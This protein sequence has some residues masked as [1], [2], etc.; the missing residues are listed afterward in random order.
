[1]PESVGRFRIDE[2]LGRGGMGE[3]Y[4]AFDP[5]L[6]RIVALK[7]VRPDAN[8]PDYLERLYREAQACARLQHPHIV[9]V[10]EAGEIDGLVFIVMEYLQGTSLSDAIRGGTLRFDEKVRALMQVLE[11]LQ[12]AHAQGVIHRDIKPSNVLRLPDGSVKLVDFGLARMSKVETMTASGMVVGTLHYASPEQFR[13]DTLDGRAD[14][15]SAGAL[16]YEMF[17][18]RL[19]FAG[20][21]SSISSLIMSVMSD[22]PPPMNTPHSRML[23]ELEKI[24]SKAMAKQASDRYQTADEMREALA[25]FMSS[26]REALATLEN[27]PETLVGDATANAPTVISMGSGT[28]VNEPRRIGLAWWVAAAVAAALGVAVLAPWSGDAT[29]N[30]PAEAVAQQAAALPDPPPAGPT[31]SAPA[32]NEAP[33]AGTAAPDAAAKISAAPRDAAPP[34]LAAAPAVERTAKELFAA[35]G[36]SAGTGLRYR[37]IQQT[38][39]GEQ[40]VEWS[41]AF[42]SG[43]KVRFAFESNVDG[44]LYVV[45]QGSS[46]QWSVLFPNP[47]INGGRNSIRRGEQYHVPSDDWFEFDNN[48]GVEQIFVFLSRDPM[49]QL[50]GFDRPVTRPE[51]VRASVVEELQHSIRPRD[52]VLARDR[53]AS[54]G[55]KVSQ[56]TYV[57]NRSEVGKAVAA[58][59]TLS[60]GQ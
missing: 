51:S 60:H 29:S 9:T 49:A 22:A 39:A 1:M 46:G 3:V 40:D 13:G 42:H 14:I 17:T 27:A 43:D 10:F 47:A 31:T 53:T 4:K 20:K 35:P 25:R 26:S 54:T 11:A 57:V 21:D 19:P 8:Q 36:A 15:Y 5:T 50:P 24:V 52:L 2:L 30:A 28:V 41:T 23:P 55:G 18:G 37:L 58:S 34:P 33:P 32:A 6:Q 16:A 38:T 44:Y 59:M 12:H 7:T 45:Q 48:P 56:A